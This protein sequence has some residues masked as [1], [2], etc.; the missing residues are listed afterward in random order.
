MPPSRTF[1]LFVDARH[2]AARGDRVAVADAD[3]KADAGLAG[4]G[5]RALREHVE[6][7]E[8]LQHFRSKNCLRA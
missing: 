8:A 3:H 4:L 1:I 7:G 5:D 6:D 2:A